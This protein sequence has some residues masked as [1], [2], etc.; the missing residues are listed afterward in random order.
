MWSKVHKNNKK[1]YSNN[2]HKF[3]EDQE[4]RWSIWMFHMET[5]T[6]CACTLNKLI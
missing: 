1:L 6:L 5:V 2:V 3:S 4:G